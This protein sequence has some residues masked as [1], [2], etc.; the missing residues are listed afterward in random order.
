MNTPEQH[1]FTPQNLDTA[2]ASNDDNFKPY[3][4]ALPEGLNGFKLFGENAV[5]GR[6]PTK[7][8]E[9]VA[10]INLAV[11]RSVDFLSRNEQ[12]ATANLM[13]E[14]NDAHYDSIE[15]LKEAV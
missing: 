15:K 2:R 8:T 4:G 11:L 13:Q 5:M 1:A 14:S 6:L 3:T 9:A 12:A 7:V 10:S